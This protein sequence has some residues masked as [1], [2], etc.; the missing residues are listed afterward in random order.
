M[1]YT[2]QDAKSALFSGHLLQHFRTNKDSNDK[3]DKNKKPNA[4]FRV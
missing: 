4:T 1:L 2:K 3:S